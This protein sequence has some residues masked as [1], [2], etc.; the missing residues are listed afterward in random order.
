V[1][2]GTKRAEGRA[3][4]LQPWGLF[5]HRRR[6]ETTRWTSP[7]VP[8]RIPGAAGDSPVATR[9]GSVQRNN[10]GTR[11]TGPSSD[12]RHRRPSSGAWPVRRRGVRGRRGGASRHPPLPYQKSRRRRARRA[13]QRQRPAATRDAALPPSC[14]APG[15]ARG[16]E[17]EEHK[18]QR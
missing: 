13:A 6:S 10:P 14:T 17:E 1:K 2:I 11:E 15:P 8:G 18:G 16:R 4:G 3:G 5:G 7:S 12:A 9:W